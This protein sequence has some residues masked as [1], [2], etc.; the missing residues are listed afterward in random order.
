MPVWKQQQIESKLQ[1]IIRLQESLSAF[2]STSLYQNKEISSASLARFQAIRANV[3]SSEYVYG[4]DRIRIYS[5]MIPFTS[6]DSFHFF[7]IKSLDSSLLEEISN[8]P[9]GANRLNILYRKIRPQLSVF[10]RY[11]KI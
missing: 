7:P 11:S 8:T 2:F 4:I 10:T 6:G 3:T 1:Q 5:D 9:F